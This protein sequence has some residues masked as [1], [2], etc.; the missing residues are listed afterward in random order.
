LKA[1][2]KKEK[3]GYWW[4][5]RYIQPLTFLFRASMSVYLNLQITPCSR[6][7]DE[8]GSL[9][10]TSDGWMKMGISYYL[11]EREVRRKERDMRKI[12]TTTTVHHTHHPHV[13][14]DFS[15]FFDLQV[16]LAVRS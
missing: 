5:S 14:F 15:P 7:H 6:S 11:Y 12:P 3:E 13:Y 9:P 1:P 2:K 16:F 10:Q 4:N 8:L